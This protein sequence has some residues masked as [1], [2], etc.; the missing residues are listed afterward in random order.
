MARLI[1]GVLVKT[2]NTVILK[3]DASLSK[4][5]FSRVIKPLNQFGVKIISNSKRLPLKIKGTNFL[6]PI[7]YEENIRKCSSKSCIM[8]AAL[9]L[10]QELLNIK[11]VKSRNHSELMFKYLK[12]S[13]KNK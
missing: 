13:N 4:R 8:L 10:L 9:N 12:N 5:D 7:K 3:G 11:A 6:K 2:N 1:C